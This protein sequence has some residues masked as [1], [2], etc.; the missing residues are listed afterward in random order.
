[1]FAA[2]FLITMTGVVLFA[3]MVLVEQALLGKWHES[4]MP[5]ER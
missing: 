3:A 5:A 1:M 2:L 4:S